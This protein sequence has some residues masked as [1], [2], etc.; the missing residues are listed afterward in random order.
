MRKSH[1]LT[2]NEIQGDQIL[3]HCI[4]AYKETNQW[5]HVTNYHMPFQGEKGIMEFLVE[6]MQ[7]LY[8]MIEYKLQEVK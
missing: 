7:E 5:K 2:I 4:A 1:C 8:P 3:W 6:K